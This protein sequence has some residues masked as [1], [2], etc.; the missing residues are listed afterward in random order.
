M[1]RR[2]PSVTG[3]RW[4]GVAAGIQQSGPDLALL[5]SDRPA[6]A[7]G[8]FTRSTAPG[9]PVV[10]TRRR[11]RS[12]VARA[13]LVNAGVANVALGA[14]GVRDAREMARCAAQQLGVPE[15]QVLVAS[16]G[17]IGE[18]LPMQKITAGIPRAVQALKG[19]GAPDAAR[20]IMTTDT[21]AKIAGRRFSIGG[22][23]HALLGI[24]KGSGMIEPKMATMLAFLATDAAVTPELLR[25]LWREVT[26]ETFN[27]VTVDGETSTSDMALLLANGAAGGRA[28]SAARG[29]GAVALSRALF[30]VAMELSRAL[31]RDGEGARKLVN[32]EVRGAQ[33]PAA[34]ERAA[35]RIAN[36]LL[37]KTALFGGDPNWGRILQTVGA[38]GVRL[39]IGRARVLVGGV[40]VFA[41][42][43]STGPAARARAGRKLRGKEVA[44]CMELGVGKAKAR[45]LTCDLGY[46]YIRINA[47]YTT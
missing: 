45:I 33:N 43:A 39:D 23:R 4:A 35:R 34:A 14:R 15:R 40:P 9:A 3:F 47:E 46:D 41:R 31:A 37:V 38:A 1:S 28:L 13:V 10:L 17:I 42:G 25:A 2:L 27:R 11:I 36:S 26:E 19:Q 12:G 16:T 29:P 18:P 7:A 5:F 20:A 22:R 30:E 44:L 21:V 8:V 24:A 32:V 6:A